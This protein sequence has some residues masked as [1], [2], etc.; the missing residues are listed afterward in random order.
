MLEPNFATIVLLSVGVLLLVVIPILDGSEK[1][2]KFVSLRYTLVTVALIMSLGCV[3][4]FSHLADESR[5]IVLMGG[6]VLVALF[7]IL[8]SLEKI[9]LG[10]RSLKLKV[11]RGDVS[12]EAELG[13]KEPDK[14]DKSKD[15]CAPASDDANASDEAEDSERD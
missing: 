7:V 14:P 10:S 4:D 8:R 3:L 5:N 15:D 11:S 13:K 1:F 2:A 6:L 12:A 9:K